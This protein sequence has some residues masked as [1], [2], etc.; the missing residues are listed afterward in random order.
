MGKLPLININISYYGMPCFD[1]YSNSATPNKSYI[2]LSR[3]PDGCGVHGFDENAVFLASAQEEIVLAT[4]NAVT[5]TNLPKYSQFTPNIPIDLIAR[6]RI[7]SLNSDDC[8][9]AN[10]NVFVYDS[11]NKIKHL[12]LVLTIAVIIELI[13]LGFGSCCIF[14][15]C[16]GFFKY[17]TDNL[18][19]IRMVLGKGVSVFFQ[20][21]VWVICAPIANGDIN[22]M[23]QSET[24]IQDQSYC[25]TSASSLLAFKKYDPSLNQIGE[26]LR[27]YVF[28][29]L[30]I[31]VALVAPFLML[32]LA[33]AIRKSNK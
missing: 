24:F 14:G 11:G 26:Q 31:K 3:Q 22:I 16:G 12:N 9:S 29:L 5:K 15:L 19:R 28:S 2:L 4:N 17:E 33:S 21:I 32:A 18:T 20:F 23:Q 27:S 7:E 8:R 10:I 30:W 25:F 13:L 1:Y 6:Y